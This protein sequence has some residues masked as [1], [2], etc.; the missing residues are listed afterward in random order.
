M[1][2]PWRE[3]DKKL[4]QELAQVLVDPRRLGFALSKLK[5]W[6][7]TYY[8]GK[9]VPLKQVYPGYR[10]NH[11]FTSA[12]RNSFL[13]VKAKMER[14]GLWSHVKTIDWIG[15]HGEM[16]FYAK[17][18]QKMF[19]RYLLTHGFGDWWF[20]NW[21]ND[22]WGVRSR[23]RGAQLHLRGKRKPAEIIEVHIDLHNPGDPKTGGPSGRLSELPGAIR[24][25]KL[26]DPPTR[27]VT[28]TPDK[29][30]AG[31]KSQ[32]IVVPQVR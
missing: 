23:F 29:L 4:Q 18:G 30:R 16:L 1:A 24:H 3:L 11:E 20:A 28:H 25:L 2:N 14:D 7:K 31:L 5:Q 32:K 8:A 12:E 13:C 21:D 17:K 9:N 26:D 15:S 6:H 10:W 27:N 19:H 22:V